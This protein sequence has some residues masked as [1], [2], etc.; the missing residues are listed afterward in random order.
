M[1]ADGPC[2]ELHCADA[3][4]FSVIDIK[5]LANVFAI[6]R[7]FYKV[8]LKSVEEI[9]RFVVLYMQTSKLYLEVAK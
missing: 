1:Q 8:K 9:E 5:A 7:D 2:F 3:K 6:M 4:T